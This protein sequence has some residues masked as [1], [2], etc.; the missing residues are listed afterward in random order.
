MVFDQCSGCPHRWPTDSC[1]TL[2][3]WRVGDG[4]DRSSGCFGAWHRIM[5]PVGV[6]AIRQSRA[7]TLHPRESDLPTPRSLAPPLGAV[8]GV[9][10]VVAFLA[11]RGE[12]QQARRFGP[13]VEY[14][15]SGQH[16][17]R[18]GPGVWLAMFRSAPLA[19]P[20]RPDE[21][22]KARSRPPVLRIPRPHF[23]A[24]RHHRASRGSLNSRGRLNSR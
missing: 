20:T 16:H 22:D 11:E 6:P 4:L 23:R 3:R 10:G 24:N 14:V 9:V 1:Q 19:A 18:A 17:N 2:T 13:L 8:G 5:R 15:G 7:I 21:S 12:V